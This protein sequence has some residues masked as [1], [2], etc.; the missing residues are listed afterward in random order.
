MITQTLNI[1]CAKCGNYLK[2]NNAENE[3]K[4]LFEVTIFEKFP[5]LNCLVFICNIC[6]DSYTVNSKI[7]IIK[8]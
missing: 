2:T 3:E 5:N 4:A 8:N 1:Q 7:K 6:N